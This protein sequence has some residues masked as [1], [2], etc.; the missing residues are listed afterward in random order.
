MREQQAWG[1]PWN[2]GWMKFDESAADSPALAEWRERLASYLDSQESIEGLRSRQQPNPPWPEPV[3]P[4]LGY[5]LA[6]AAE[7]A[8]AEGLQAAITWAAVH[9]WFESAIE[10]RAA[11]IRDLGA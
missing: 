1:E 7:I 8:E 6:R 10:T 2:D 5:L 11:V 9:A 4:M 3:N